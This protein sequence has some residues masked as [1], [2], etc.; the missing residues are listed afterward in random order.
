MQFGSQRSLREILN[1]QTNIYL[2]KDNLVVPNSQ[3][4]IRYFLTRMTLFGMSGTTGRDRA[5][6]YQQAIMSTS[7]EK[8]LLRQVYQDLNID[9][10][11]RT[12]SLGTSRI[13]RRRLME[14]V[15]K[16]LEID[17]KVEHSVRQR[18]QSMTQAPIMTYGALM[19]RNFDALRD[20]VMAFYIYERMQNLTRSRHQWLLR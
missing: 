1:E 7:N 10:Q 17:D 19:Y 14:G 9:G 12:S 18:Y 20:E 16:Y 11:K 8:D 3:G 15:C 6:A 4:A 13:Y 5:R 2:N